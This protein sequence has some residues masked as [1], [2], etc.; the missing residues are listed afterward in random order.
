MPLLS[1]LSKVLEVNFRLIGAV[2]RN[3]VHNLFTSFDFFTIGCTT[4]TATGTIY[5]P[6]V[7]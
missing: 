2:L 7:G 4:A 5:R 6:T 1:A 3:S